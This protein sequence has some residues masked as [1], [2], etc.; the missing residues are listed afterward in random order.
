M[1]NHDK[2][3]GAEEDPASR[4]ATDAAELMRQEI[5]RL[6]ADLTGDLQVPGSSGSSPAQNCVHSRVNS[7]LV[8]YPSPSRSSSEK[9]APVSIGNPFHTSMSRWYSSAE[10]RSSPFSSDTLAILLRWNSLDMA[11]LRSSSRTP[12]RLRRLRP[13]TGA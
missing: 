7:S 13:V 3:P 10:I 5:T 12:R 1:T 4:L 8:R 9:V 6:R 11:M 2:P